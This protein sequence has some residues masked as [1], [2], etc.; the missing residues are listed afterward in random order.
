MVVSVD[1]LAPTEAVSLLR[2]AE[3]CI[4]RPYRSII[5]VFQLEEVL[6]HLLSVTFTLILNHL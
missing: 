6:L 2:G 1:V 3:I 4:L 5:Y